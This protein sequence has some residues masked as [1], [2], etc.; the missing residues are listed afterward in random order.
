MKAR[1]SNKTKKP[2]AT[3]EKLNPNCLT[4]LGCLLKNLKNTKRH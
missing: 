2:K 3:K 1:E 4:M